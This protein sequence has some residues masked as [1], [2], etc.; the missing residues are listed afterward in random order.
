MILEK[1]KSTGRHVA[2]SG[3][4]MCHADASMTSAG[5]SVCAD[6]SMVNVDISVDWST[7]TKSTV[8]RVSGPT[9][10]SHSVTDVG[11]P[12]VSWVKKKKWKKD[13]R[14]Y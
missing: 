10:R 14:G 1:V 9:C 12:C 11:G 7:L 5:G 4:A 6:I 2:A 13:S 3:H 8:S